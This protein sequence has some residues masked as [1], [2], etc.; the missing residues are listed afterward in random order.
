LAARALPR[1]SGQS[2][3]ERAMECS[4][5]AL[6]FILHSSDSLR[7]IT[8]QIARNCFKTHRKPCRTRLILRY[9]PWSSPYPFGQDATDAARR[10]LR[11]KTEYSFERLFPQPAF[12]IADQRRAQ[13]LPN[14]A[15]A[16][17]RSRR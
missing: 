2:K 17:R 11:G 7:V 6:C 16:A 15:A 10:S 9:S 12:Q 14:G 8:Q 4:F 5:F 3:A 1:D 13:L